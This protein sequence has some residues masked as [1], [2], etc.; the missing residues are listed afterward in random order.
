MIAAYPAQTPQHL[1]HMVPQHSPVGV[2]LI[3]HNELEVREKLTPDGMKRQQRQVDHLRIGHDD[4]G[5]ALAYPFASVMCCITI[6]YCCT[7][8][9]V[10]FSEF[11]PLVQGRQLILSQG[12]EG[13]DI[14]CACLR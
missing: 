2:N 1:D 14:E 12:L 7:G 8:R 3:D 13:E 4:G 10:A 5:R 11:R 9:E 6:V